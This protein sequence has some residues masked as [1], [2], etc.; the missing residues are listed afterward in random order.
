MTDYVESPGRDDVLTG[1][2][3][4]IPIQTPSGTF[5][6]WTKRTGDNPR[7]KLL[8]LHGGPGATHEV[9]DWD[10]IL[11]PPARTPAEI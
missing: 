10:E 7:L 3:R 9:I 6:V 8:L 2:I 1:G 11:Q 4:M 5:R